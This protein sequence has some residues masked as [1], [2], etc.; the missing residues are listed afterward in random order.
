MSDL[1]FNQQNAPKAE[2]LSGLSRTS[3]A[4]APNTAKYSKF[5]RSLRIVLPLFALAIIATIFTWNII[6]ADRIKAVS[7]SEDARQAIARNELLNPKFDSIDDS[8]QPYTVTANRAV[9]DNNAEY[10][11]LDAPL[12]DI[13]LN[14]GNWVAIQSRQG[15]FRQE[16]QQLLL[17]DDVTLFHDEGYTLTTP[18]L[19]VDLNSGIA[20]T[21]SPV[22]A[23]GPMGCTPAKT[24]IY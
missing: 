3:P 13:V 8:N 9:Q 17:K 14:S 2:R 24:K 22:S 1:P 6:G 7:T 16:S 12:A 23:H 21:H 10:M 19:D 18:S 11:L 5:V 4:H 20:E 15:A